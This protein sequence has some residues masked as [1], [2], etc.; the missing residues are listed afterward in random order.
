[1][2]GLV[3]LPC[4]STSCRYGARCGFRRGYPECICP[5]ENDC[6]IED[7]PVCGTDGRNYPNTCVLTARACLMRKDVIADYDGTCG[8]TIQLR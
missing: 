6:P 1:M 5:V 7:K 4:S 2:A 3:V 8:T